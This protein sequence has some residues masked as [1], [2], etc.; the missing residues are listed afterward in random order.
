[1]RPK[2]PTH[3]VESKYKCTLARTHCFEFR[4]EAGRETTQR[5]RTGLLALMTCLRLERSPGFQRQCAARFP[6]AKRGLLHSQVKF[7]VAPA[8]SVGGTVRRPSSP[9]HHIQ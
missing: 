8:R 4:S 6:T 7:F 9:N 3:E 5:R 2:Y 1:M